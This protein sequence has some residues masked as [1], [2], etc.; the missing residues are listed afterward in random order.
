MEKQC[1][2]INGVS[3]GTHE[4]K[5]ISRVGFGVAV[6]GEQTGSKGFRENARP[7]AKV[8]LMGSWRGP[9]NSEVSTCVSVALLFAFP[10]PPRCDGHHTFV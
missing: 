2:K 1:L 7:A 6:V 5:V 10:L 4:K 8:R 9:G 3:G